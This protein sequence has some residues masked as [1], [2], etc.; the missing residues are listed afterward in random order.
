M[1]LFSLGE[2]EKAG[3]ATLELRVGFCGFEVEGSVQDFIGVDSGCYVGGV[4]SS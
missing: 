4:C 3:A 2:F 1:F